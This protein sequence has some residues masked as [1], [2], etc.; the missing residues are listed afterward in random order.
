MFDII[1][2]TCSCTTTTSLNL[3]YRVPSTNHDN[4]LQVSSP[5]IRSSSLM[6]ES[7]NVMMRHPSLNQQGPPHLVDESSFSQRINNCRNNNSLQKHLSMNK[8]SDE[9]YERIRSPT[10]INACNEENHF[11]H[12]ATHGYALVNS[13][14]NETSLRDCRNNKR[15]SAEAVTRFDQENSAADSDPESYLHSNSSDIDDNKNASSTS[16]DKMNTSMEAQN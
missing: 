8:S 6:C 13:M 14:Q 7:E 2:F 11:M 3:T 16:I 12:P 9:L 1:K 5:F 10:K 4:K 15:D